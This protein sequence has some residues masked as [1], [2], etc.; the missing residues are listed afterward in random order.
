M[1]LPSPRPSRFP[2]HPPDEGGDTGV[3]RRELFFQSVAD[4]DAQVRDRRARL[5]GAILTV[6]STGVRFVLRDAMRVLGAERGVD[7]FGMTGRIIAVAELLAMGATLSANALRIGTVK[8]D[9][10]PGYLVQSL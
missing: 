10:Q 2:S 8:Y 7:V 9:V 6:A 1:A 3:R 4:V 5:D